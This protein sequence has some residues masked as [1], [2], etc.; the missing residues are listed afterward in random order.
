MNLNKTLPWI[1]LAVLA[2]VVVFFALHF[3]AHHGSS[4][5]VG[6]DYST[7]RSSDNGTFQ[8]SYATSSGQPIVISQMQPWIL[9]VETA[10][11]KPA[12]HAVISVDGGMPQHG[13]GLPTVPQ[14]TEYLGNGD[15]LVEGMKFQM[16]GWWEVRFR[17]TLG[18]QTDSVTFNLK[19]EG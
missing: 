8:V 4:L 10:D 14:V 12:E 9:H 3:N 13:H 16:G 19:L 15:Y 7:R 17:I 18:A 6:L 1:A 2:I 11:G 5:P